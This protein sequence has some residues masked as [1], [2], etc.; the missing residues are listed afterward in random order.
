MRFGLIGENL[1]HSYSEKIHRILGDYQYDIISLPPHNLEQ[2]MSASDYAGFNVTIPYKKAVMQYC[3]ELDENARRIGSVNTVVR[4]AGGRLTGYNTDYFGFSYMC[5]R[6]GVSFRGKKVLILGSGGTSLTCAAVALDEGCREIITVSR[7]G[8]VNYDNIS[9]HAD[10]EIIINTTP[11]GMFPNN[12]RSLIGL[13]GFPHCSG[14][15]DVIY[16]PL[17]TRLILEAE[18]LGI[19]C[20]G[21]LPML[22][23]QAKRA[24]EL[25]TGTDIDDSLI[26]NILNQLYKEISNIVLIGMPGCG[27]TMIGKMIASLTGREFFDTDDIIGNKAGMTIPDIFKSKGEN[28]FRDLE[29]EVVADI[30]KLSGKVIS[31]GGGAVLREEN[32]KNLRQ[33][34]VAVFISRELEKLETEGRP[35]STNPDTLR[36]MYRQRLPVYLSCSDFIVSNDASVDSAAI[37]IMEEF[38]AYIGY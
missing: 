24:A 3:G 29:S 25:F 38:N 36:N 12:G 26:D 4:G 35:L 13:T 27:K 33:N 1:S 19:P 11:V 21:G 28:H 5:R 20:A 14:V 16:N 15:L 10:S 22:V 9:S 2:F 31:V 17:K 34:G 32:R 18:K 37:T 23:A 8:P 30:G 7:S 6:T